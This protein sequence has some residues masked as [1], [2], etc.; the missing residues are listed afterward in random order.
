MDLHQPSWVLL[1]AVSTSTTQECD[2]EADRWVQ[3]LLRDYRC[4]AYCCRKHCYSLT[5]Q[6]KRL[7]ILFRASIAVI[8]HL[9]LKERYGLFTDY[10]SGHIPSL[11]DLRTGTQDRR[12]SRGHGR[13]LLT[14]SKFALYGSPSLLSYTTPTHLPRIGSAHNG[15]GPPT[16]VINQAHAQQISLYS[17][18]KGT[19]SKFRDLLPIYV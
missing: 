2:M 14:G 15:L 16:S 12:W 9:I 17:S 1:D 5:R 8:K 10:I 4:Q 7:G 11:R 6:V 3:H 13:M 18:L 19:F